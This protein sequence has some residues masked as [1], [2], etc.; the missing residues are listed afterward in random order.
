M[1]KNGGRSPVKKQ[2][3]DNI[4]AMIQKGGQ[5][6]DGFADKVS[7]ISLDQIDPSYYTHDRESEIDSMFG[8]GPEASPFDKV[9]PGKLAQL[10]SKLSEHN[11]NK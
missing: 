11:L 5:N 2:D 4:N 7:K 8:L 9:G 1:S 3:L 10:N 6:T